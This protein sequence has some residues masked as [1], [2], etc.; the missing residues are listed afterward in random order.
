VLVAGDGPDRADLER[1]AER[2]P[3]GAARFLGSLDDVVT[4]LHAG[5]VLLMTSESEG[6]PGVLIEAGLCGVPAVST[7]VGYVGDVVAHGETGLL[8]GSSDPDE[9]AE[10]LAVVLAD[11]DRMGAAARLRC[12]SRF[13]LAGVVDQ[14]SELL[15][16]PVSD[17]PG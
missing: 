6:V 9:I 3:R 10:A 1:R 2:S 13:E 7:D 14:W 17:R 15:G 5:D 4:L 12:E 16:P 8:V 11:R